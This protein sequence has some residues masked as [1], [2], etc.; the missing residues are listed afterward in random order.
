MAEIKLTGLKKAYPSGAVGFKD[1]NM[2]IKDGEF[3]VILGGQGSGKSSLVRTIC[4]LES[5]SAGEISVDNFVINKFQPKDRDIAIVMR[6]VGL[7]PNLDIFDNLSYGLKLRKT[8][9]AELEDRTRDVA[10]ILGLTDV[11][12]RRPKNVTALERQR[13]CIGRAFARKP[14]IIILD[15]PFVDFNEE[16]RQILCADI[17]K[18]QKRSKINFIYTTRNASEALALADKIAY[19]EKGELVQYGT[20]EELYDDPKTVALARYIG[21]PPVNLFACTFDKKDALN[22]EFKAEAGFTVTMPLAQGLGLDKYVG[23][24]KKIQVAVRA[25]NVVVGADDDEGLE[26]T[27]EDVKELDDLKLVAFSIEGD[28]SAHYA[29]AEKEYPFEKGKKAKFL[30]NIAKANFFDFET[31]KNILK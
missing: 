2:E 10:R 3:T 25:E 17:L 26:G 4:G 18:L 21:E 20:P 29:V 15:D 31:E 8:P 22:Y 14:R 6:S 7:Y 19:F 23:K 5:V 27:L 11:L 1:V 12:S 24:K 30:I 9:Q 28:S 16:Q 13:T